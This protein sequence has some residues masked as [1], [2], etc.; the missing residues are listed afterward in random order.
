M[1]QAATAL[2]TARAV[3]DYRYPHTGTLAGLAWSWWGNPFFPA[4]C[5]HFPLQRP[6]MHHPNLINGRS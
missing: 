2:Q 6:A 1:T 4:S 3:I 5:F